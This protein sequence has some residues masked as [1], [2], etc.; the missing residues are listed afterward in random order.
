MIAGVLSTL[1]ALVVVPL[2]GLVVLLMIRD[3]HSAAGLRDM[4]QEDSRRLR[5]EI[6]RHK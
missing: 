1:V 3:W 5:R 4:R 2:V 6:E